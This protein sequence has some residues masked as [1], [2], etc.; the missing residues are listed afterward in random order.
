MKRDYHI[1]DKLF[2]ICYDPEDLHQMNHKKER[3][4]VSSLRP[5]GDEVFNVQIQKSSRINKMLFISHA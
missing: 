3:M 4:S 2:K 5:F 1:M